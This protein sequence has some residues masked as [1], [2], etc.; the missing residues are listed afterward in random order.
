MHRNG[1]NRHSK[2]GKFDMTNAVAKT[3]IDAKITYKGTS[4]T[5]SEACDHVSHLFDQRD[6]TAELVLFQTRDIGL[7]LL[8][9]RSV[10]KSD[11]QFGQAVAKT[12]LAKRSAQDR[13][14]AMFVA[15]NWDKVA[16]LNKNG[17]LNSL[18]ASAVRK[19]VKKSQ[20]A[21]NTSKGKA[22]PGAQE[23]PITADSLAKATL[24]VLA[25]NNISLADFRKALTKA[26]KA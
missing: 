5:F 1:D 16:K 14:D 17:E 22:K 21:G 10:Y 2:K 12:P 4:Y 11:K 26:S 8:Q 18:G 6:D 23:A 25:D 19:R 3:H 15:E 20:S 9:L 24:K 13:N 7:W